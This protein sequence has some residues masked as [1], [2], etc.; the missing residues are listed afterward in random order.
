MVRDSGAFAG[1]AHYKGERGADTDY[2][3]HFF[4]A[5]LTVG[6]ALITQIGESADYLR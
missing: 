1:I 4:G 3:L 6:I 5:T 2:G